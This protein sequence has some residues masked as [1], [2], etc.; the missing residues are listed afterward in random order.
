MKHAIWIF[1]A[2][3]TATMVVACGKNGSETPVSPAAQVGCPAG[4]IFQNGSCYY[5]NGSVAQNTTSTSFKSDNFRDRTLNVYNGNT[6]TA[7]LRDGMAICDRAAYSYGSASCT[8]YR[9]G[10]AQVT[11]QSVNPASNTARLSVEVVPQSYTSY[12]NYWASL[13]SWQQGATCGVTWLVFGTCLMAPTAGQMQIARNPLTID[14]VVSAINNSQGFEGRGYGAYG[15]ISQTALIQFQVDQGKL[16][17]GYF[18]YKLIYN[19]QAGG[20]FLT[21]RMTKC[22]DAS[23]GVSYSTY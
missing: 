2:L 3:Y 4:T 9:N 11:L 16:T 1:M 17:D 20:V 10:Y 23:C 22:A 12:S 7:F 6:Y 5:P 14:L 8:D 21:G 15:T 19:G 18:N 13:P